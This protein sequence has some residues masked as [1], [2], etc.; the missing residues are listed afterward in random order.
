MTNATCQRRHVDRLADNGKR[1]ICV[2]LQARHI[3]RLNEIAQDRGISR[4]QLIQ[5]AVAS[6]LSGNCLTWRY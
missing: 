5:D 4:Q 6:A 3:A 2:V 1:R